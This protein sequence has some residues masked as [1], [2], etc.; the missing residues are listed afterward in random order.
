MNKPWSKHFWPL[1]NALES[2]APSSTAPTPNP[3]PLHIMT[4][5]LVNFP[6][7]GLV[8]QHC[9]VHPTSF[10]EDCGREANKKARELMLSPQN[11]VVRINDKISLYTY[12]LPIL[13][14][15]QTEALEKAKGV[16]VPFHLY[17]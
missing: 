11:V 10:S 14:S 12:T 15:S 2:F 13:A 1:L 6:S 4:Y 7:P 9:T 5:Y 3:S 16:T 8:R 17:V